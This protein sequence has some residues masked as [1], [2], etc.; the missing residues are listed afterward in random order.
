MVTEQSRVIV[1]TGATANTAR[2]HHRDF[3]EIRADGETP[4]MAATHLA[5]QLTR[6]LDSALTNWRRD[7]IG[8]A[9]AD[10]QAFVSEHQ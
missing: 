7:T 1:A 6:A 4:V 5:N 10:I 3:P 8:Q 2:V 9:I